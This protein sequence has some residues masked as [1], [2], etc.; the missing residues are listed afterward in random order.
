MMKRIIS[1][2]LHIMMKQCCNNGMEQIYFCIFPTKHD[3]QMEQTQTKVFNNRVLWT[4]RIMEIWEETVATFCILPVW[5]LI[6]QKFFPHY[7]STNDTLMHST[8]FGSIC[9]RWV[10]IINHSPVWRVVFSFLGNY[11]YHYSRFPDDLTI[12]HNIV[13]VFHSTKNSSDCNK[14]IWKGERRNLFGRIKSSLGKCI[15][16][17]THPNGECSQDLISNTAMA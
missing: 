10:Q 15:L 17:V 16:R 14:V 2:K 11:H 8:C 6:A 4:Y 9:I 12:T 13:G 1:Y 7:Y 5:T 3:P